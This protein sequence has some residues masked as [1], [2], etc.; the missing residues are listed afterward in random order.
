MNL[1]SAAAKSVIETTIDHPKTSVILP[2]FV[3]LIGVA[4]IQSWLTIISMLLGICAAVILIR[5]RWV[6][7]QTA[8]IELLEAKKRME[9]MKEKDD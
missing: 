9:E 5:H 6:T 7:L 1:T 4:T 8:E 2:W 3:S